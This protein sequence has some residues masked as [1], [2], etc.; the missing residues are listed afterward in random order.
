MTGALS[1]LPA[2]WAA[3]DWRPTGIGSGLLSWQGADHESWRAETP[4]G[5]AVI[6]KAPRAHAA[7]S[8]AVE[9]RRAAAAAGVGPEV[10]AAVPEVGVSVEVA[11]EHKWQVATALRVQRRSG[12]VAAIGRAR[13]RF[14]HFDAVL[15]RRDMGAEA[16]MLLD[17]FA[18]AGAA[19]LPALVPVAA[20]LPAM[21]AAVADGPPPAPAWLSSE[22][23]DLQLGADGTIMMTGGTA[24]GSA[25]PLADVGALLT[26]L[27]P[28]VL[29]PKEAFALLW[30]DDHPGAYARAR[31]WGVIT[32]LWVNL[33]AIAAHASDPGSPVGYIGYTM[34]RVWHAEH[35]VL[36]GEL[37][38]LLEQAR[39]GWR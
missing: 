22:L 20:A 25:D 10:L 21:R 39:K 4:D 16:Q 31:I 12:T 2:E 29:P 13:A 28:T 35:P 11:L 26:E 6:A 15:P 3:L 24:A 34:F 8:S 18:A 30:E 27:S 5:L 9:A 33:K 19:P 38:G 36:T 37:N 17:G 32:D 23:S 14:R 1:A 7:G